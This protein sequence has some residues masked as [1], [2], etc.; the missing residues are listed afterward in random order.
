MDRKP[1]ASIFPVTL[2]SARHRALIVAAFVLALFAITGG[3]GLAPAPAYAVPANDNLAN[4]VPITT[5]ATS[6]IVVTGS[7]VG[8]T[9][10]VGEN[11]PPCSGTGTTIWYTWTSPGTPGTVVFDT[12]GGTVGAENDTV[13]AIYTGS[14]YPLTPVVCN[15]DAYTPSRPSSVTLTYA[16]S[17]TYRIQVGGYNGAYEGDVVLNIALGGAM[18]VNSVADTDARDTVLTLREAI[19]VATGVLPYPTLNPTEQGFVRNGAAVGVSG[20]DLIHFVPVN[21]PPASP[22]TISVTASDLPFLTANNDV[23]SGVG[24]GVIIDGQNSGRLCLI[25]E[26]NGNRI[27]GMRVRQCSYVAAIFIAGTGNTVGGALDIQRNV[28][29]ESASGIM[30]GAYSLASGTSVKGNYIGTDGVADLGMI[31][32]PPSNGYGIYVDGTNTTIGGPL[33]GEGNLIS[34]NPIG[35]YVFNSL[36]TS[37]FGNKIG[38]DATGTVP[39]PNDIGG[40]GIDVGSTGTQVGRYLPGYG[41]IIAFNGSGL[42]HFGVF[43]NDSVTLIEGNSIHSNADL[44]ISTSGVGPLAPIIGS[45]AAGTVSGFTCANCRVDIYNDLQ[46][47]GRVWVGAALANASGAFS[48]P[49]VAHALANITATTTDPSNDTSQFSA[50][51]AAAPNQDGDGLADAADG[52]P[53]V[54]EDTDGWD[55]GD[56]CPDPDNDGDGI[57]DSGQ[58]A[59]SC[60]GSD[61]GRYLWQAPLGGTVDC[62]NVAEDYDSFH[63]TDGC[64]EPD[65]D[66]DYFPD[67]TDDCPAT[68]TTAGPDGIADTGDEPVLYL[69]PYQSREDF[70][71]VIDTD[72]CHD[73]PNDDYDGDGAGDETEVFTMLTDPVNPDTD[74]DTVIDGTDN[75]PNWPNVAQNVPSW[76]IPANDSDCDG[77]TVVREQFVGTDPTKHCNLTTTANDEAVDFWPSDFNDNRTTNLSDLILMGPSYNKSLGNP[78]YN[79][80]FDLNASNSVSLADVILL[81]PFYNRSCG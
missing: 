21:F 33:P 12:W 51:F 74:A 57:C 77:F 63:D 76:T 38:T 40:V 67:G 65:N 75:C 48:V 35:V 80:R 71:G 66:Y 73:S 50:P 17:T 20:S 6:G 2:A 56:G 54:A 37:V 72:G 41:N 59:V 46:D 11:T 69:T 1:L 52:C 60:T 81:G 68:D 39:I 64:P 44:G 19:L 34:G 25:V 15:D 24:A 30:I 31:G 79:Q 26:G 78:A 29:T 70:D 49:G 18:Y 47:E 62:R 16:A 8:A 27:E 58:T 23:L 42:G 43:D 10:E 36:N 61:L 3:S 28:V 5:P 55:D 32:S 53:L 4:A 7:N 45:V 9:T 22:A 14:A 13:L